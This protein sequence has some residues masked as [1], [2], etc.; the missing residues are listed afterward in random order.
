MRTL[1]CLGAFS[2]AFAPLL[3]GLRPILGCVVLDM[4]FPDPT[5][6]KGLDGSYYAYATQGEWPHLRF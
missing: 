2:L 1:G 5:V 4:D 3:L 6:I